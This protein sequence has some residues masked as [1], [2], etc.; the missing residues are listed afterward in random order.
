[1]TTHSEPDAAQGRS[2]VETFI[3]YVVDHTIVPVANAIGF[4]AEHGV[5]FVIFA[6]AWIAVGIGILASQGTVDSVWAWI[7]DLPLLAQAV[8]WLLFL[9]VMAGLWIWESGWPMLARLALL[10]SL[11]GWN[12]LVFLPRAATA[13]RP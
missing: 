4:M 12:L 6:V 13:A 3:T 5:L 11:A 1:M 9:P 8:I 7:R 2:P 10:I